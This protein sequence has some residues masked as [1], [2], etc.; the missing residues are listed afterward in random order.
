LS[1]RTDTFFTGQTIVIDGY[2]FRIVVFNAVEG[3]SRD[4][5]TD[6][7]DERAQRPANATVAISSALQAFIKANATRPYLPLREFAA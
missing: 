4:A 5:T 2:P 7:A 6:V 3:W 1:S